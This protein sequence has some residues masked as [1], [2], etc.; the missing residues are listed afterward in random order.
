MVGAPFNLKTEIEENLRK[1]FE[2]N[3]IVAITRQNAPENFQQKRPRV[4]IKCTIGAA[5][6]RRELCA[7]GYVRD[8]GFSFLMDLQIVTQPSPDD[9]QSLDEIYVAKVRSICTTVSQL[10]WNDLTNFPSIFIAEPLRESGTQDNLKSQDG[11]EY[12]IVGYV[13]IVCI[14]SAA[15]TEA[16]P[17]PTPE[18]D[19]D[20]MNFRFSSGT[21]P[22]T[23]APEFP[24]IPNEYLDTVSGFTYEWN[25]FLQQWDAAPKQYDALLTQ[26]G[27]DA[28]EAIEMPGNTLGAIT[29]DRAD[30]GSYHIKSTGLFTTSK[31]LMF[32]GYGGFS[33]NGDGDLSTV[34]IQEST[35][36]I[37]ITIGSGDGFMNG[38]PIKILVYPTP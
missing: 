25:I 12:S 6:G 38:W 29:F 26:S 15:F 19:P 27:T 24:S 9:V 23:A 30:V 16:F 28:P 2:A 18:P 36:S 32:V 10:T 7:D 22:P 1:V 35:S 5:T 17:P 4:E 34:Y 31:T 37:A 8:S 11:V 33:D 21:V 14:R 3:E 20:D 13:G